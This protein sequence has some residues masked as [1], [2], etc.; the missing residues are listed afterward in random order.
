MQGLKV[1]VAMLTILIV[2]AMTIIAYGMYRKSD[3]PDFKFFELG[4]DSMAP[5]KTQPS[6]LSKPT[7]HMKNGVPTPTVFGEIM[8]SLPTGCN[9]S[10][11]SGDG[12]R[13]FF[14]VGPAEPKCERVIVMDAANGVLL[15]TIKVSQ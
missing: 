14:K 12:F 2:I 6:A 1:L 13:I 10:T 11:V 7:G 9:I 3:D 4:G 5:H 8:L 15:G